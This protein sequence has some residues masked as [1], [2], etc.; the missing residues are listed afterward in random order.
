MSWGGEVEVEYHLVW[1]FQ[2][3][4][5]VMNSGGFLGGIGVFDWGQPPLLLKGCIGLGLG[6]GQ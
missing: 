2:V 1:W 6:M 3:V 5:R 4:V